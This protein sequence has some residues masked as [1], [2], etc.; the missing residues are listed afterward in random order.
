[1][2]LLTALLTTLALVTTQPRAQNK[3]AIEKQFQS[4]LVQI[5]IPLTKSSAPLGSGGILE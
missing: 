4:W 2:K 5:I 1:M 3:A